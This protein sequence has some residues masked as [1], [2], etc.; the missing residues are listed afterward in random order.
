MRQKIK[1]QQTTTIRT[2]EKSANIRKWKTAPIPSKLFIFSW[3]KTHF[4]IHIERSFVNYDTLKGANT[5]NIFQSKI[6]DTKGGG[7]QKSFFAWRNL[8]TPIYGMNEKKF[9]IHS[10]GWEWHECITVYTREIQVKKN[11]KLA[12]ESW[13]DDKSEK[14]Y[15]IDFNKID[16]QDGKNLMICHQFVTFMNLHSFWWRIVI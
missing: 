6:Y 8:W 2:W 4:W 10:R 7:S 15:G 13:T 5:R 12:R 3:I 14:L 16:W 11:M 1:E 9:L